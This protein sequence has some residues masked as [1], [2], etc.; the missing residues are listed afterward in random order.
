MEDQD[1][2]H[3]GPRARPIRSERDYLAAKQLL[4]E[5]AQ[6]LR[7][8]LEAGRFQSLIRELGDYESHSMGTSATSEART[9]ETSV[10][11]QPQR[12]WTDAVH[13]GAGQAAFV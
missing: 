1:I 13:W 5:H 2:I 8:F 3:L 4:S 10:I 11:E 9:A 12:R 6:T 7:P